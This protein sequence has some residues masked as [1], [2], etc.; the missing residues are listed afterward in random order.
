M[1]EGNNAWRTIARELLPRKETEIWK[2]STDIKDIKQFFI[3]ENTIWELIWE[4]WVQ[5]LQTQRN[6]IAKEEIKKQ[7]L[8][9]NSKIRIDNKVISSNQLEKF[10][11]LNINDMYDDDSKTFLKYEQMKDKFGNFGSFLMYYAVQNAIPKEWKHSLKGEQNISDGIIPLEVIES[12]EKQCKIAKF[13]YQQIV[14][15]QQVQDNARIKWNQ[16]LGIDL[17]QVE[18]EN[19]RIENEKIVKSSKLKDF[20]YRLLSAR[21]TTNI[22]RAR[23]QDVSPT[24]EFCKTE[25]ETILHVMYECKMVKSIWN[26]L[27]KWLKYFFQMDMKNEI[28]KKVIICNNYKGKWKGFVNT[29]ILIAKQHIYAKKCQQQKLQ[30]I[31]ITTKIHEMY[32][33]EKYIAYKNNKMKTFEKKWKVYECIT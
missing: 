8:T 32:L 9:L 28:D 1:T 13:V 4:A 12:C 18:W 31:E 11:I 27:T 21:I 25:L 24:C 7:R 5:F 2:Y 10:G 16:E 6:G 20:Q 26:A 29:C 33:D 23:Y 22:R 15:S 19:I 14:Q 17:N 30:F 3:F